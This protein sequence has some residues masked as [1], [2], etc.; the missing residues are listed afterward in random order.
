M[1]TQSSTDDI[2]T[3]DCPGKHP[4]SVSARIIGASCGAFVL[5]FIAI[6]ISLPFNKRVDDQEFATL[7]WIGALFCG[8]I[9]GFAFP[10]V[11]HFLAYVF[12]MFINV[13]LSLTIGRNIGEQASLFAIFTLSEVIFFMSK[14]VLRDNQS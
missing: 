3:Q 8:A 7:F 14:E 2:V 1:D 4:P 5:C 6:L 10:R 9:G 13:M 12:I 11:G